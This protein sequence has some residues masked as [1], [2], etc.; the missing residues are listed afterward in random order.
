MGLR[1]HRR[2]LVVWRQSAGSAGRPGSPPFI[3]LVRTRRIRG[4]IRTGTLLSV[5]AV[6]RLARA[7]RARWRPLLA[8]G[9]LTVAGVVMRGGT[10]GMVLLPG[11][12]SLVYAA[13]VP[14]TTK[15]DRVR[16]AE[17][18]RELAGYWTPAQRRDLEAT[19]DR[20]PDGITSE[21]RDILARQ[22]TATGNHRIP[23]TGGPEPHA[24]L[25]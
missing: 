9:V 8:G 1:S 21:I 18:E 17:L 22:A 3:R 24:G 2:S 15:T 6:L 16:H 10:G 19:L 14:A 20:Y 25:R 11:L 7:A 12:V 4:W 5:V 13:L 23:G